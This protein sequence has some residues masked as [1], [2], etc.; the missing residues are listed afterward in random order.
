MALTPGERITLIKLIGQAMETQPRADM[1][2]AL[3]QFGVEGLWDTDRVDSDYEYVTKRM[4]RATDDAVVGLHAH[5]YPDVSGGPST[6]T[7][8]PWRAGFFRLFLSHTHANKVLAG[9]LRRLLLDRGI[10]TFVAHDM[11]EPTKEWMDEIE[12]ALGT[13][14]AL[15]AIL[16]EDFIGSKWCDQEVGFAVHRGVLIVPIRQGADPH[17]F[18]GKYQALPGDTTDRAA[19]TLAR[20]IF[21]TLATNEMTKAKM[22]PAVAHAYANSHSF[23]DARANLNMLK[24]IPAAFW[25][26]E[27]VERVESAGTTN[28]QLIDGNFDG[29]PIPELV[30]EHLDELLER[31]DQVTVDDDIP[32]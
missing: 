26:D 4:G 11:I 3:D 20:G 24:T 10:D 6:G 14:D 13:C 17:G 32:S 18:I 12:S 8:G 9:E 28:S 30:T 16:T 23:D 7:A 27:M 31:A 5:M 25:T 1:D 15:A 29:R 21:D 19:Y 2:L 22:A